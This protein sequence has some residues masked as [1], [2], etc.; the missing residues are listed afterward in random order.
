MEFVHATSFGKINNLRKFGESHENVLL[1][2]LRIRLW[3]S[4]DRQ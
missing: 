4:Y 3:L 2:Y 1:K